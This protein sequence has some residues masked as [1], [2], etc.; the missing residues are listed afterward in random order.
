MARLELSIL[1]LVLGRSLILGKSGQI[2]QQT[3]RS[4]P[5]VNNPTV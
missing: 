3:E 4:F 1:A 2:G 5:R